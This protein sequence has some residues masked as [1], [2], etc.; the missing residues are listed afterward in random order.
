MRW[1]F[2]VEPLPQ[3]V[4]A[5]DLLRRVTGHVLAVEHTGPELDHLVAVLAEAEARL[6]ALAPSDTSP[7]VGE[8]VDSAGRAYVDHSRDIGAFNPCFPV[9]E[10][11]VDGD[12]AHGTVRFPIAYEGPPGIVHGG[13]LALLFDCVV[14]HHNCELGVAG[15]TASLAMRF[16]RPTPL[17][18]DL[19]LTVDRQLDGDRITSIARLHAGDVLLSEAEVVAVAGDRSRLPAVSERRPGP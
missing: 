7:R 1:T 4:V 16:R 19:A 18:A 6:A 9:Y 13:F 17:L 5:A 3:Q 2:G 12:H 8:A 10:L 11:D 14:Q 15:K